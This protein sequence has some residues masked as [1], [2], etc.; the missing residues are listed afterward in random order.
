MLRMLYIVV[1]LSVATA[2]PAQVPDKFTNLQ[3]FPKDISSKDLIEIMRG[4]SFSLGVRCDHCH[5]GKDGPNL[6][7][8]NFASDERETKKTARVMLRM[9]EAINRD[10][11]GKVSQKPAIAVECVTCHRGLSRPRTLQAVLLEEMEKGGLSSAISLYRSLRRQAYGNGQYDFSE[12]SLNLLS[13]SLLHRGKPK[14]AAAMMELNLEVNSPFSN[15]GYSVLAMAHRANGEPK[16]AEADFG[17][18][19]EADP[20]NSWAKGEL[21]K[22]RQGQN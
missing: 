5:A 20:Q 13:E 8:M 22:L 15:W 10:Y 11:I 6:P 21:E 17:K 14:E 19:L 1:L 2:L 12:T 7:R 4:F 16:K 3:V 18:I 9:V